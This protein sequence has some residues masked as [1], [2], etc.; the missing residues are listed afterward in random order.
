MRTG[1]STRTR[2]ADRTAHGHRSGIFLS[3]RKDDTRA[4]ALNLRDH[5][6][7]RFGERQ[8]FFDVDSIDAG[9]WRAEID[10]ALDASRVLL[11]LIGPRWATAADPE[12]HRRLFLPDDVHRME[13][14]LALERRDVTVL[15]VL[16]DGARLPLRADLPDDLQGLLDCQVQE[17]GDARDRRAAEVGR[18]TRTIEGL[19]GQRDL[20]R[21]ALAA[22]V[23][24]VAIGAVNATTTT[25]SP[26]FASAI[27]MTAGSVA[28]FSWQVYRRMARAGMKGAL[29]ALVALLFSAAIV[30][31]SLIRLV[32][33]EA[34]TA[35]VSSH[36]D[37]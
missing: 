13:I 10:R 17:I 18:L 20:R 26:L 36:R 12:G 3:Y 9:S 11:V 22:V 34:R 15:P 4:W 35:A 25:T 6:V 5:L 31:G 21:R 2:D 16:V 33:L 19:T 1:E 8:V 28:A 14:A 32:A 29:V 30:A 37:S 24:I 27:L 7:R 23:A